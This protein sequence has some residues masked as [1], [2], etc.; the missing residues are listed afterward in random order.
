MLSGRRH[1]R[2]RNIVERKDIPRQSGPSALS[3]KQWDR[4]RPLAKS[5]KMSC[6]APQPTARL[7]D[8][9]VDDGEHAGRDAQG[10]L[11]RM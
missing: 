3:F 6:A 1:P 7:F 11:R 8:H 10:S 2:I 4:G 5:A 9:L